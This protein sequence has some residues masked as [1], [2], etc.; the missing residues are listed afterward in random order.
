MATSLGLAGPKEETVADMVGPGGVDY[1][2]Y[3]DPL[4]SR[5]SRSFKESVGLSRG[6]EIN[7]R[8]MVPRV[9]EKFVGGDKLPYNDGNKI[10]T[11]RFGSY[12]V[13]WLPHSVYFQFR[14][15]ANIYFTIICVLQMMPFSPKMP[16]PTVMTFVAVLIWTAAKDRYE[17]YQ[18][19]QSDKKENNRVTDVLQ[20]DRTW[21]KT[22]WANVKANDI[23]KVKK[24]EHIP[25]D[26]VV[27]GTAH[28]GH[29][30]GR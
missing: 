4:P 19:E 6:K 27:I 12:M 24:D 21:K 22:T 18:R 13:Q 2:D 1:L 5:L 3:K 29:F 25:A 17:D 7:G 16:E 15:S 14:R 9:S 28:G 8:T 20:K 23:V 11:Q 26:M 30:K 10:R